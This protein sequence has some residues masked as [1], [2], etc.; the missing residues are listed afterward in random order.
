MISIKQLFN[1][2]SRISVGDKVQCLHRGESVIGRVKHVDYKKDNYIVRVSIGNNE[3]I[4]KHLRRHQVELVEDVEFEEC[5]KSVNMMQG[6]FS[7]SY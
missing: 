4:Y 1:K 3:R 6:L 5:I 7:P 2:K